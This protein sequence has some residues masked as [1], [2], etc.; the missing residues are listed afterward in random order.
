MRQ[1][2]TA[3]EHR[4]VVKPEKATLENVVAFAVYLVDPPREIDQ[5]FVKTLFE[6]LAVSFARANSI[7]VVNTPNGPGMNRRIQIGELPLVSGNLAV[8]MLKLFKQQEPQLLLRELRIDQR[9][10]HA[11]KRQI[12]RGEPRI[13]PLIGHR[14]HAH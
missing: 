13:L 14:Q 2:V 10:R 3:V 5:Q 8:R 9:E 6:K 12:P 4:D 11:M 1:L 7:H